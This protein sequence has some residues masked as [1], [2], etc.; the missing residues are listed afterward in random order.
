MIFAALFLAG[1]VTASTGTAWV[2]NDPRNDAL[3]KAESICLMHVIAGP[4]EIHDHLTRWHEF[5]PGWEACKKIALMGDDGHKAQSDRA[6]QDAKDQA[7][8]R[9]VAEGKIK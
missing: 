7:F 1:A 8:I 4:A 5:E 9:D 3:E 2:I 6:A